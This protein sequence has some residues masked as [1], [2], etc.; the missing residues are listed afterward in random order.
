MPKR[1]VVT[2]RAKTRVPFFGSREVAYLHGHDHVMQHF[3]EVDKPLYHFGNGA[4]GMGIHPLQECANCT[5]F[6]WGASAF[7]FAVHEVGDSSMVVHFM[8]AKTLQVS[9]SVEI[10]FGR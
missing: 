10:P 1:K 4:G 6:K 3:R 7:G 8:D 5:E 9:H 2:H